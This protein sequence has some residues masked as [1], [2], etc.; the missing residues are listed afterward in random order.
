[1][2]KLQFIK[3]SFSDYYFDTE[4]DA[5]VSMKTGKPCTL[6]WT[7]QCQWIPRRVSLT[8]SQGRKVSF[9]YDQIK[10]MVSY[11]EPGTVT[12]AKAAHSNPA[13]YAGDLSQIK[14][15]FAYVMFSNTNKCSQYFFAGTSLQEA[16]DRLARRGEY[17]DFYD[18]RILNTQTNKVSK[19]AIKTVTAYTLV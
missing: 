3:K 1:M 16:L 15:E 2:A 6:E 5:V 17:V 9:R 4:L 10:K 11:D 13:L 19:L 8:S 12:V 14:P 18:I 7:H